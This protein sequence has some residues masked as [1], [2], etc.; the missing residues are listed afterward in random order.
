MK[1]CKILIFATLF[2][3]FSSVPCMAKPK[4]FAKE[5]IESTSQDGALMMTAL[6]AS[7]RY[8]IWV[9]RQ[10]LINL[11]TS[12]PAILLVDRQKSVLSSNGDVLLV[13]HLR[14]GHYVIAALVTQSYFVGCTTE[15]TVGFDVFPGKITYVGQL[16]PF[17]TLANIERMLIATGQTQTQLP[18]QKF[19]QVAGANLFYPRA[20]GEVDPIPRNLRTDFDKHGFSSKSEVLYQLP[21]ETKVKLSGFVK[22]VGGC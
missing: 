13:K 22:A 11:H 21:T 6:F 7:S 19:V 15:K 9:A 3:A 16:V 18:L 20:T 10:D 1:A 12:S 8:E 2:S 4:N 17:D 5:S 14:P